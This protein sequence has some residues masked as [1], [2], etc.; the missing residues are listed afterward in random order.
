MRLEENIFRI[1]E[2]MGLIT[3]EGET[4][5]GVEINLGNVF[6]SGKYIVTPTVGTKVN[7]AITQIKNFIS[8]NPGKPI[9]VTI[10]SS[11]SKVPNYDREKFPATGN[12]TTDFTEDKKL[13]VG[14]LSK[15]RANNL[16]TYLKP[17]LPK[18]ATINIVDKGSQGPPWKAPFNAQ[19]P[20]YTK[21][22]YVKLYAKLNAG[23]T[24]TGQTTTVQTEIKPKICDTSIESQGI[25]GSATKGFIAEQFNVQLGDGE[26]LFYFALQSFAV[27]DIL[28]VEYNGK[29][30]TTGLT[31]LDS[32]MN[33]LLVGTTIGNYY[34]GGDK[35]WYF[36]GLEISPASEYNA[37]QLLKAYPNEWDTNSF[38]SWKPDAQLTPGFFTKNKSSIKPYKLKTG[39]IKSAEEGQKYWDSVEVIKIQ[40]VKGVNTAKVSVV[41]IVGS[42]Q[43]K[44]NIKCGNFESGT[45]TSATGQKTQGNVKYY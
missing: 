14:V 38:K 4:P 27:P 42:T 23:Q 28:I 41:G 21:F 18:N 22:Q 40:Q 11:E 17:K 9:L 6:E 33:R 8:K 34:G 16:A 15:N 25:Y 35:P 20:N 32:E 37:D 12:K 19:D 39:Q 45:V 43:W 44:I 2:V 30:Y 10:E 31:G 3:E 36:N 13:P 5:Q 29:T 24:V 26:S 7:G 1:K